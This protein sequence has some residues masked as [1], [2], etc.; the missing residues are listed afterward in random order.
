M[1]DIL[2]TITLTT[3]EI[4]TRVISAPSSEHAAAEA[5]RLIPG[6]VAHCEVALTA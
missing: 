5:Y 4:I 1:L 3:G 6:T 2:V